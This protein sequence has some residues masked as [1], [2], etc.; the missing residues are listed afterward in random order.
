MTYSAWV[1]IGT[2]GTQ[3]LLYEGYT[4][5]S[6]LEYF[7]FNSSD[8]LEWSGQVNGGTSYGVRT[9]AVFRDPS[10]WY[11]VV[12]AID[13]TQATDT[14][15][16]KIYV[17]GVQQTGLTTFYSGFPAQN[18]DLEWNNQS[19][20]Q[21]I[22]WGGHTGYYDGY[23]T[24]VYMIDGQALT[25]SSFGNTNDQTGV[26]QPVAY[27]GTYGT[28]GFYLPFSNV[29]STTT[30]GYDFSG[31]NNNWTANNISLSTGTSIQS[32][33]TTGTTSWTAPT[34]VTSVNYLVVAGG[35]GGAYAGGG[36]AGGM[37]TGT[38]PVVPGVSYTVTVGAGGA[39]GTGFADNAFKGSDS[40]FGSITSIGG[41]AG[42]LSYASLS[43]KN[44]GGS[45]GAGGIGTTSS[46]SGTAGQGNNGGVGDASNAGGG[47]GA[48]AAGG[49]ASGGFS[50]NGGAGLASSISGTSVTYAGGG[51]GGCSSNSNTNFGSGGAGGGG[52]SSTLN[53]SA[54]TA[55]TGGGGGGA[56]YNGSTFGNGGAGGSGIVILSWASGATTTYDSMVDVPTQW[57]PYNT[58]GDVGA[59]WRGNYSVMNPLDQLDGSI[60]NGNLT[61]T[62]GTVGGSN[63][64]GTIAMTSGK[65]YWEFTPT[66]N[67]SI[68]DLG[69]S[70]FPGSDPKNGTLYTYQADTGNKYSTAG[71]A[72]SFGATYTTND[73][74]GIAYDANT[75][76]IW[77]AKNGVFQASGDPAAGTNAAYTGITGN[78]F[79]FISD[80]NVGGTCVVACNFGQ[81]PFVY[82]PPV[83]F[84][85]LN[86]TNLPTPTIGATSTTQASQNFNAVLR[87]GFG[88]TGGTLA[89]GFQPDFVWEKTR[90][91]ASS[92]TLWDSNRGLPKALRSNDTGAELNQ[93]W[94]TGFVT[95]GLTF[96]TNDYG[97]G[98]S[99]V[100]WVWKAGQ[101][102]NVTNNSGTITSTVSANPAAGFS[103]VT[104]TGN[105]TNSTVG[106]GLGATPSMVIVKCRSTA[107]ES[108]HTY[109][110]G[111]SS[112]ANTVYLNGTAAEG[113][114]PTCF[115]SMSTLNSTVFSL[116][117]DGASN[118]SGR[119]YVAYVFSQVAGY[120]A[121]GKYTGNDS[122]NGTFIYT[123]FRP[124]F[125]LYKKAN[126]TDGWLIYD[127]KRNS[128]NV[129]DA[130][131]QPNTDGAEA[132]SGPGSIDILSNGFKQRNANNIGNSSSF[133][134]IYM[135]FAEYPFKYTLAR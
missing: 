63:C 120:S 67:G 33:T 21:V 1:K 75:G 64:R 72:V 78:V 133:T 69:I 29:T 43:A 66:S 80:R 135:A 109:H 129:T 5:V 15:R 126:G 74:I 20:T 25:P 113:S 55:N 62:T 106:H 45:G 65:F 97:T 81:R 17:N 100:E 57:I 102:N 93:T 52:S 8:Q 79:P 104:Y 23:M 115:N 44:S 121:F 85:T 24:E 131:L 73:V 94:L 19:S 3:R 61:V 30:I 12:I 76:S 31:N 130:L 34:G 14:N 10:A 40:V 41:G 28:N 114:F 90:S 86:T 108:W 60:A 9:P 116:G 56:S 91:A 103:I 101:G 71:G 119:T 22:A 99:L 48:G 6:D 89:C 16:I 54:G 51:G 105:G 95:N 26:G 49:N 2:L 96:G 122:A 88:S 46:G 53:G 132:V 117:T 50:G 112:P 84:K 47:G 124:A 59:L 107:G 92:H 58:T 127:A 38:I 125:V 134:Y 111:L 39:G 118:G 27:T 87:N 32:F 98:V 128:A 77:W 37:R 36:G 123:G 35:G 42:N 82:T 110:V 13:T 68:A 4:S 18:T 70:I 83:G 7:M 11:H